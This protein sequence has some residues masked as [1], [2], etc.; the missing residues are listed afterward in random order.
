[1]II[2]PV[3][4]GWSSI[5]EFIGFYIMLCFFDI[6]YNI[7]YRYYTY[8]YIYM[9]Q[10]KLYNY[11]YSHI[12]IEF[13]NYKLYIKIPM[14]WAT[15]INHH[16]PSSQ[17]LLIMAHMKQSAAALLYIPLDHWPESPDGCD[18]IFRV[19]NPM[20]HNKWMDEDISL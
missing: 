3:L 16:S 9:V 11:I 4:G 6:L 12:I 8:I 13:Y 15:T 10:F 7:I 17:C 2:H 5:H 19:L 18:I 14:A 1:M 20:D